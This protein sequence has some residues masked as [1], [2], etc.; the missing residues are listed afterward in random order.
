[1]ES[2][3]KKICLVIHSLQAGGMERVMS[4]IANYFSKKNHVKVHLV[5]YGKERDIFYNISPAISIHKPSFSFNERWRAVATVKTILFV[6]KE[7]KKI[8]PDTVLSMGEYWNSLV[9]LA[10][11]GLGIP[12]FVSDRSQPD[13]SLGRIHNLLRK[14][15]Y[16]FAKGV[17]AQTD[18]AKEIFTKQ[19]RHENITVIGNPIKLFAESPSYERENIVLT[20][21]RLI[22]SKHHDMLIKMF[23][24]I[25]KPGW[26][27]MIIGYDHL[28]QK[29]QQRLQ[30]LIDK[31]NVNQSVELLGK[32]NNVEEY[33]FKSKIF[34][35]T[36]SSEGFPN[37]IG[38]A[39]SAGLPVISFDCVAG[40][41]E[42]IVNDETGCL[43]PLFDY[44]QFEEKLSLLMS[45]DLLREKMG[46]RGRTAIQ[47]FNAE[48]IGEQFYNFI[49]S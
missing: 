9:L 30:Q 1:M 2:Q 39:M 41:S 5:L 24:A 20:V 12:V 21:G 46:A 18:K 4:E 6:R 26:K 32:K 33:Y 14:K 3:Y 47:R 36:S 19:Y 10:T 48:N 45:D 11:M 25:N 15:L 37:V 29:N 23:A 35:F 16:P 17:I 34:A 44:K 38:E 42:M 40:P 7:I 28:K 8:K 43:I 22:N 31:L 49:L 13:K 27:L